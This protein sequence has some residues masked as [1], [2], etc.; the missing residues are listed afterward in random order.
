MPAGKGPRIN[1][2]EHQWQLR[3]AASTVLGSNEGPVAQFGDG[4][5]QFVLGIHDYRAIPG[6]GLLD[7]L[8]GHEKETD[9][10]VARFN[11]DFIAGIEKYQ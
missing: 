3:V 9:A 11:R 6:N 7:G 5:P 1:A 8:A 2:R 4:F 10:V